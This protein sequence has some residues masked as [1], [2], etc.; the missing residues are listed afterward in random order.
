MTIAAGFVCLDGIVLCADTQE[1][2]SGYTKNNTEK[3]RTWQDQG[4][5]IAITGA[6]DSELIETVGGLIQDALIADYLPSSVRMNDVVRDLI[7]EVI[8]DCFIKFI[9]PYA[10]FPSGERPSIEL[11]IAV[12][13][14]N[15]AN[16]YQV[17]YKASGNTVREISPGADCIGTGLILAKS[18]IERFYSPFM[19]LDEMVLAACYIM[20]Q[21]KKWVDGCGGK[22]DIVIA[23]YQKQCFSGIS[24][25]DVESLEKHFDDS[26]EWLRILLIDF[27]NPNADPMNTQKI[28]ALARSQSEKS[29]E[30][31][32]SSG[33]RLPDLLKRLGRSIPSTSQEDSQ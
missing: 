4:L 16:N 6:G 22:T 21:T 7:Q 23:S 15:E 33:S 14:D 8:S 29:L 12:L 27:A 1:T 9:V 31:M 3:I 26:D 32:L 10:P 19:N 11:L 2:I 18:L 28:V 25:G 20:F 5:C 30:K 13:V 24:S 17:L